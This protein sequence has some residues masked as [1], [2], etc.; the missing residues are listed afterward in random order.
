MITGTLG[1]MA[2]LG[3]LMYDTLWK[4]AS[5]PMLY[6]AASVVGY[7]LVCGGAVFSFIHRVPFIGIDRGGNPMWFAVGSSREQYGAEAL[8]MACVVGGGALGWV[9]LGAILPNSKRPRT[10]LL[11]ALAITFTIMAMGRHL[12]KWKHPYYPY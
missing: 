11:I 7:C 9:L 10:V 2:I 3:Y 5:N 8:L 12:F 1:I 4:W 6:F